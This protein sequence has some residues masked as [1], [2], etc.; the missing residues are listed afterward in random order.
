MLSIGALGAGVAAG[1][2]ATWSSRQRGQR[3]FA[4]GRAA[5]AEGPGRAETPPFAPDP[6]TIRDLGMQT[7]ELLCRHFGQLPDKPVKA[8]VKPG[9]LAA[10]F[11]QQAPT[12]GSPFQEI[13]QKVEQRVLPGATHWQHPRFMAYYPASTSVPAV[14]AEAVIAAIGSVGLQWSANPIATELEVV[15]MDWL[16]QLL[17]LGGDF[18]HKSGKGGGLLQNTAGEAIA[19]VMVCARVRKHRQLHPS[20]DWS[21]SFYADSSK[22]VVYMSDQT[23]FSGP[24][25]CR[26]AGLRTHTVPA[27]FLDGNYRLHP[28]D[29]RKAIAEDKAAGLVPCALQLNYGSTNTCGCDRAEDFEAIAKEEDLWVHIDA[30]Y[31]GPAWMLEEHR[32]DAAA[33]ARVATSVNANGSK[34]FLCG[35]DSAF[36]WV[37]DRKL[38]T[39][40]FS[41]TDIFM[42]AAESGI[43]NPEFKDWSVPLG[44]RFRSLRIW[45]VLEYF[46]T[47]GI[48]AY[49]RQ[50][51]EQANWLRAKLDAHPKFEQ[52][53]R[54]K[55]GLIC[56]R[57]KSG[58][59]D[60]DELGSVLLAAG[61]LVYP[62]KI[63]GQP[64][65]RVALGG[66]RTSQ[67]DVEALW[68]EI[69]Q[70]AERL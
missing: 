62:S 39:S 61:F 7:L 45:L 60:T 46:G 28:D 30:A 66:A 6:D 16:A 2:L 19:N 69:R 54:N 13:L 25:A 59:T 50:S 34:W 36:L 67:Q 10:Q 5:W 64:A 49:L 33:V 11:E 44:R 22:L 56:L 43:Y 23:H 12:S 63:D 26:V 51:V 3:S 1:L 68:Q 70:F 57:L 42:A 29:L 35:F 52:P 14:L 18:L 38:L 47:D 55:M 9:E 65:L 17:G 32:A 20:M 15:V 37:R 27:R 40:V 53:A 48:K 58:G 8:N 21:E 24:K 41:A 4:T 31:A